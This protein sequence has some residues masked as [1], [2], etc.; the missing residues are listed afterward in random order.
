MVDSILNFFTRV[1]QVAQLLQRRRMR[2]RFPHEMALLE[3]RSRTTSS[4]QSVVLYTQHKCA[5][6]YTRDIFRDLALESGMIPVNYEQIIFQGEVTESD[7]DRIYGSGGQ[8][9]YPTRG[10]SFA[11]VRA[12][13]AGIHDLEAYRLV[14][15]LRDPRDVLVSFYFSMAFSHSV[16]QADTGSRATVLA[17]RE[18]AT[19]ANID[20]YV[21]EKSDF[22]LQ[23]YE[24]YLQHVF[25]RPNALFVTY[26]EM[27]SDFASW[28][29]KII[30]HTGFAPSAETVERLIRDSNFQVD[31]EDPL[32]HRRQVSPGDHRR[33]LRPETI[34]KLNQRFEPVLLRLGYR[35]D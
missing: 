4:R 29:Q 3:G 21:M 17:E 22:F 31:V 13:H 14:L 20:D 18:V 25:D 27:I 32:K 11:P 30:R 34:D 6:V 7:K 2:E 24:N 9:L 5:S 28:L 8:A 33:K 23:T 12:Y 35:L 15:M 26:E 19:V 1:P 10:Y 16:P